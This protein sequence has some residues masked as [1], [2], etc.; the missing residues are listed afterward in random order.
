MATDQALGEMRAAF[1]RLAKQTPTTPNPI[2]GAMTH[3]EW[4]KLNLR[5]AELHLSFFHPR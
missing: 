4:V 2:F 5:H 3:D 1:E